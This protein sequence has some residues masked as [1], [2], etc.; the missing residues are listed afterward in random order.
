MIQFVKTGNIDFRRTWRGKLILQLQIEERY[1][2]MPFALG[3]PEVRLF[4]RD[5]TD[6]EWKTLRAMWDDKR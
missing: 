5:A 1:W 2:L 6:A 4:W 3:E